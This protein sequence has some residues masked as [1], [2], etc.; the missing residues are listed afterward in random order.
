MYKRYFRNDKIAIDKSPLTV[1]KNEFE[2]L[3]SIW[4]K[5][6]KQFQDHD[7]K[8]AIHNCFFAL[9]IDR[10]CK[11]L[12][13]KTNHNLD[14]LISQAIYSRSDKKLS[15]AGIK[16]WFKTSTHVVPT[17]KVSTFQTN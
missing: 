7:S 10:V 2:E 4:K 13:P 11:L 14:Q 17:T 1:Q 15:V 6:S 12:L 5:N 9:Q 3:P 8:N 16:D